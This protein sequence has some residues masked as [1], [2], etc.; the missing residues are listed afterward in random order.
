MKKKMKI[1]VN[2][3]AILLLLL[4]SIGS[5]AKNADVAILPNKTWTSDSDHTDSRSGAYSTVFARCFSVYPDSGI[6]TFSQIRCRGT[7]GYG[8][9]ISAE[10]TLTETASS[11]QKIEIK[12]GELKVRF[13]GFQFRGNT[14]ASANASVLYDGR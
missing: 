1:T 4:S 13:V 5:F 2:I 6:D 14:N 12:E 11:N 10:T 7:N 8:K 9:V 3:L